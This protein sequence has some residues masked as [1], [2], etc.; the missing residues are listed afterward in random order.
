MDKNSTIEYVENIYGLASNYLIKHNNP[1]LK[2]LMERLE[3]LESKYE[4]CNDSLSLNKYE[5]LLKEV[6]DGMEVLMNE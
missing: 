5:L 4:S 1:K 2:I 3:D 6:I